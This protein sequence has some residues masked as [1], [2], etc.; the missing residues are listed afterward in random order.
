LFNLVHVVL[1]LPKYMHGGIHFKKN[2]KSD[3]IPLIQMHTTRS[4]S[5]LTGGMQRPFP[6]HPY[7][8]DQ[9]EKSTEIYQTRVMD[10][11][12]TSLLKCMNINTQLV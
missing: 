7:C 8:K 6:L 4:R 11:Q 2:P 12:I 1:G 3:C 10:I 5:K 9:P